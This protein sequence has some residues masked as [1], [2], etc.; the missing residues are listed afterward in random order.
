[1]NPF[2]FDKLLKDVVKSRP[3]AV[4]APDFTQKVMAMTAEPIVIADNRQVK[5]YLRAAMAVAFTLLFL[6]VV[7][8]TTDIP[9][10]DHIF[11]FFSFIIW[12]ERVTFS[13]THVFEIALDVFKASAM[14]FIGT[15]VIL[16]GLFLFSLDRYVNRKL[17][18]MQS[19]LFF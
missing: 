4:P 19:F 12:P 9:F 7:V 5:N 16:A 6:I 10:L 17:N 14:Y 2:E 13:F 11:Q 15:G 18:S 3:I 1:M 8:L